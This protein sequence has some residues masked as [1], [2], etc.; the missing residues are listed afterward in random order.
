MRLRSV[1]PILYLRSAARCARFQSQTTSTPSLHHPISSM[2]E[3][4]SKSSAPLNRDTECII[5]FKGKMSKD[6]AP[7]LRLLSKNPTSYCCGKCF[8]TLRKT[9]VLPNKPILHQLHLVTR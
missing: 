6:A 2:F 4:P 1:L 5:C 7:N 9:L 3:F 8:S